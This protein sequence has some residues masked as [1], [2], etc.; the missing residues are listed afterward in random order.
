MATLTPHLVVRD[1]VRA[2]QR[3]DLREV[4]PGEIAREAAKAFGA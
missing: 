2:A 3:C 1:V 4:S